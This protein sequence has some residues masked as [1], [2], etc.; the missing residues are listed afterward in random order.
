MQKCNPTRTGTF[1]KAN[2]IIL[3]VCLDDL[4]KM[5]GYISEDYHGFIM[6]DLF[7]G[8]VNSPK[9]SESLER[10]STIQIFKN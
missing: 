3:K 5:Q 6:Y 9:L 10:L 7:P 2:V 1:S 4:W 8:L